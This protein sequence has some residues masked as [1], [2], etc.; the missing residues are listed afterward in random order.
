V[1]DNLLVPWFPGDF[2]LD[3]KE[4]SIPVV[5][6]LSPVAKMTF[7]KLCFVRTEGDRTFALS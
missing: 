1:E 6:V 2:V 7:A 4:L 5:E 3:S